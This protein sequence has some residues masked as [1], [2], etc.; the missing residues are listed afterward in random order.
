MPRS[1][2]CA[3]R[4][5]SATS[6]ARVPRVLQRHPPA[7]VPPQR[8]P[9]STRGA[10]LSWR[11]HRCDPAGRWP[12]SPLSAR[13]LR[14]AR[15]TSGGLKAQGGPGFPPPPPPPFFPNPCSP[16]PPPPP[17]HPPLFNTMF[18]PPPPRRG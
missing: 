8:Q 2:H 6:T 12:S 17:P 14:T 7:S 11:A 13:R 4:A 3:Q 9:P 18:T 1:R 10:N 5:A 16:A 15:F